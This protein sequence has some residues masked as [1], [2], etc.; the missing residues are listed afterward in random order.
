MLELRRKPRRVASV[1]ALGVSL[2]SSL[3]RAQ[4]AAAG[5]HQQHVHAH[6]SSVEISPEVAAMLDSARSGTA[7]FSDRALAIA[8]GYRRLGMDFP[9]MGE[10][11]VSPRL[12]IDGKFNVS[13]PAMLTYVSV[14]G[15]PRLS[16]VVYAIPLSPGDTPPTAFGTEARWHEHNGTVDE[17]SMLPQHHSTAAVLT[18]TRLAILHAWVTTP[19]PDGIFAAENWTLPF[20]RLGFAVPMNFPNGAARALSLVSGAQAYFVELTD[21]NDTRRAAIEAAF[22]ECSVIATRIAAAAQSEKSFSPEALAELD[23]AWS[24][25]VAKVKLIGGAAVATR[26]GGVTSPTGMAH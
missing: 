4:G 23:Q 13:Q 14:D 7:M 15:R 1:I 12:V 21:L 2:L 3:S 24:G 18:G 16:G 22:S 6:P 10:H 20:V 8:A 5:G 19:N 26:I 17:E 9:S 25:L 11:W